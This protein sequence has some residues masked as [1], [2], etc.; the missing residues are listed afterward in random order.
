MVRT[1][2]CPGC[3]AA[4]E[5]D[6][7]DERMHCSYCSSSYTPEEISRKAIYVSAVPSEA[8]RELMDDTRRRATI[9][10]NI[11]V[12]SSCGGELA[13]KQEEVSSFC[14]YCGNATVVMDRV[15][16]RLA[17]DYVIPFKVDQDEAERIIRDRL[18]SGFYV[19][20]A[21]K[22]FELE[23]L[24]G[25]YIPFWLYDMYYG[26]DQKWK[27]TVSSGKNSSTYYAHM[28]GDCIYH[29]LTVDAS[30]AFN[31]D[32]SQRLEPYD[33]KALRPFDATYLSGFYA[34]RFDVGYQSADKIAMTRSENM[35]NDAVKQ[36]MNKSKAKLEENMPKR[37]VLNRHYG[38]L[39]VWFLT[40]RHDNY[41]YT[42]LL[43]GQTKKMV[44]AVPVDKKKVIGTFLLFAAAFCIAFGFLGGF[45]MQ[46]I[47]SSSSHH[48][49][50]NDGGGK[51]L[52]YWIM[53]TV[54][55]WVFAIKHFVQLK[56]SIELSRSRTNNRLAKERQDRV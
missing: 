25:I 32:S 21:I 52:G 7:L 51:I 34:D 53:G 9:R 24:R 31:D 3:G 14:P 15:E 56:K 46:G 54:L 35:Y 17:P 8:D 37:K 11:A 19:P 6:P 13:M 45:L 12:C 50:N 30:W 48:S 33:M 38:L 44:A 26:S 55:V 39:P 43:N 42:V 41:P 23:K 22:H 49:S 16:E 27:Y 40:F 18:E 47:M 2:K 20:K 5:Y 29:N 28:V 10:M 36:Y 1:Y 4:L